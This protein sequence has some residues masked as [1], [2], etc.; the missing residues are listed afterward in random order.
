MRRIQKFV[1]KEEGNTWEYLIGTIIIGLGSAA[2]F[3]GIL[4]A[5]RL[6]GGKIIETITNFHFGS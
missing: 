6:Q 1:F 4:A 2:I 5:L 3:F